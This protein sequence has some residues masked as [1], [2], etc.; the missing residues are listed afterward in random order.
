M[1][2]VDSRV[3]S[4]E[5]LPLLLK[6]KIPAELGDL[7]Y[8]D[9]SFEGNGPQGPITLG[10]ERKTLNDLLNCI[11]DSRYSAHQR[12]G[13]A[14][15]YNKSF[16]VL[17]GMWTYGNGNGYEGLLMQGFRRGQSWGPLRMR[18][19]R[20]TLY[21]KLYR[22]LLSISMMGVIITYTQDLAHTAY[23]LAE[24]YQYFQ[25]P[26]GRHTSML[27]TQKLQIPSLTGRP[28]L[29]RR[30]ASDL[31]GVGVEKSMAA[32]RI[33]KNGFDLA[34]GDESDWLQIP[35]VGEKTAASIVKQIRGR[36]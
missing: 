18:G 23:N 22:Y 30:W 20:T 24:M 15:L 31:D 25:K 16:L 21:S 19:N 7:P 14:M 8:G 33:F 3:G 5:L 17:E 27:E 11:D 1:M 34:L 32:D 12:P 10:V 26:W 4:K 6:L 29:V 9:C 36:K 13:M 28:S 35:G 2:L